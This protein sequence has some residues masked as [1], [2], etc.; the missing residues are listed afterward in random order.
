MPRTISPSHW[1][2]CCLRSW[3]GWHV[4]TCTI[5]C[6][7]MSLPK[8]SA[9]K[10]PVSPA[11]GLCPLVVQVT[12]RQEAIDVLFLDISMAFD[13]V[14][15]TYLLG[16]LR[17]MGIGGYL[18]SWLWDY[19]SSRRQRCVVEG[20][21]SGCLPVTSGV[22]QGT[23]LGPY[24]SFFTS[25]TLLIISNLWWLYFP[26]TVSLY[27]E[28]QTKEDQLEFQNDLNKITMWSTM[29]RM[30]FNPEKCEVL[31]LGRIKQSLLP[32]LYFL[33]GHELAIPAVTEHK[34]LGVTLTS[35]MGLSYQQNCCQFQEGA[36]LHLCVVHIPR[37]IFR[38][39]RWCRS[40]WP[41]QSWATKW[42]ITKLNCTWV[43]TTWRIAGRS[44]TWPHATYKYAN[45]FVDVDRHHFSPSHCL[46]T[47]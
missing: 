32:S 2:L 41:K 5:T 33:N 34:Y 17:M 14:P 40:M 7:L 15:H 45:G 47:M 19:L 30:S 46:K 20:C 27:R 16:K 38:S 22:P 42:L 24:L 25:K 35:E 44:R 21:V 26:M 10:G 29:W 1:C 13:R 8:T 9:L 12:R 31:Q 18:W 37:G 23:I 43:W 39:L 4:S 3:K 36:M 28:V 6:P 11:A